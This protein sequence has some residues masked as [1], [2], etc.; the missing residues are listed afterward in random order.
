VNDFMT[1]LRKYAIF[2]GR[3]TRSEF[4]YFALFCL[5]IQI[6]LMVIDSLLGTFS[7]TTG[8]GLPSG[9]FILATFIPYLAVTVRR[10]HDTDRS[11][12]WLAAA[13]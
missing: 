12:W 11:G 2:S 8:I 9:I 6:G 4:W 13:S 7:S 10:L 3:A 5:L 1:A